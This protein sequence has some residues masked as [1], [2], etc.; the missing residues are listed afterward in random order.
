MQNFEK[1]LIQMTKPDITEL[2]HGDM[3]SNAIIKGKDRSVV[4]WWWI[5]IPLYIIVI[6]L[7]KSLYFPHTTFLSNLHE[8]INKE[9]FISVILFLIIPVVFMLINFISIRKIY[10]LSGS[11]AVMHFLGRVW[12]HVL[13]LLFSIV[14]ILIYFI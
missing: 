6:L 4:S 1:E 10:I 11:P 2:K 14:I 13:I 9:G 8:L 5:S 3:L 12:N 7:M